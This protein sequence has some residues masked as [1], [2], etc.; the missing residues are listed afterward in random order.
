[1]RSPALLKARNLPLLGTPDPNL[2]HSLD[3]L[4]N[5]SA[6]EDILVVR[7]QDLS[8]LQ[9]EARTTRVTVGLIPRGHGLAK[10]FN[11]APMFR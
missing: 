7:D 3:L 10:H 9:K 11:R 1:M 2:G 8:L 6:K 4:K 5:Q